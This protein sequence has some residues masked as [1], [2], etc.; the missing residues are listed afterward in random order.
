MWYKH[1]ELYKKMIFSIL[2][3]SLWF[4]CTKI[5]YIRENLQELNIWFAE[6]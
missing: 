3:M 1:W 6:A 4:Y 2:E 5:A